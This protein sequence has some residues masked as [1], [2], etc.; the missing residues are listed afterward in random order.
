MQRLFW[1]CLAG[2]AG[3]GAR[4]V[5]AVWVGERWGSA[6]PYGTLLVNLLGCF[7]LG[8]LTQLAVQ[9]VSISPGL[10]L[11]LST[12]FLGGL[13][14]YSSFNQDTTRLLKDG[15]LLSCALNFGITAV[16]CFAA[17]LLGMALAQYWAGT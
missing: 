11:A 5:I 2:G 12:G 9:G 10:R 4:Y 16:G 1:I 7:L 8:L 6:F 13:T 15:Q 3:T 17:G 14:T